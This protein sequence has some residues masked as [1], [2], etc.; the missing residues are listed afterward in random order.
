MSAQQVVFQY[1]SA[2]SNTLTVPPGFSN[3]VLV[4][5]W[6]AG[7]GA[8]YNGPAGG[9]GGFVQGIVTVS[10]GDTVVISVGGQGGVGPRDGSGI[11]GIGNTPTISFNGGTTGV[12]AP[13]DHNDDQNYG[14]GGGGGAATS[15]LVNGVPM[16]V[17]A[18]GGGGGGGRSYQTGSPGLAGG[19]ATL[20]STTPRGGTSPGGYSVGGAGGAG[21]PFGGAGGQTFGDDAG[22]ATGGYGGQN[23][24]NA[25]VT[26]STL[27]AGSGIT[28]GGVTNALYPKA[29][30]G[31]AGYDG[32]VI[33]I[34]TKNFRA[35]IKDTDWKE[36]NNAWVKVGDTP[37]TATRTVPV[38][39]GTV[40]DNVPGGKNITTSGA[41]NWPVPSGVTSLTVTA[42]GGGGGGGAV[43]TATIPVSTTR[44]VNHTTNLY[45]RY[46]AEELITWAEGLDLSAGLIDAT[47]RAN[48]KTQFASQVDIYFTTMTT[49]QR[50]TFKSIG[51]NLL[52]ETFDDYNTEFNELSSPVYI[53]NL[54]D[55]AIT[56]S[57]LEFISG[58][59]RYTRSTSRGSGT[60]TVNIDS[61]QRAELIAAYKSELGT[62]YSS[63]SGTLRSIYDALILYVVDE[64]QIPQ[65]N[66]ISSSVN[67][68][69]YIVTPTTGGVPVKV[70]GGGGGGS[71]GVTTSTL[72]VTPGEIIQID[73]GGGGA[74][75]GGTTTVRAASGT[76]TALGGSKGS[77]GTSSTGGSGGST[78]SGGSLGS[79]GPY[80]PSG[81]TVAGGAGGVNTGNYGNGGTGE[82]SSSSATA[83]NSG[84]VLI[85]YTQTTTSTTTTTREET[86]VVSTTAGGW[87]QITQA[88]IKD[89]DV[90]KPIQSG[91]SLVPVPS[92]SETVTINLTIAANANNYVLSD[93]LSGTSYIEGRSIV[94][95]TV[96]AGVIVGS[97]SA[98]ESAM[99][100]DGLAA[101]DLFNL[102]NNGNIAGAG[103]LGGAAGSY[104]SV[105]SGGGK[106]TNTFSAISPKGGYS[107][108]TTTVTSIPGRPGESGG[109]ALY[110][111]YQTN[112]VNNGTIAG[113]GGGGGG[114]GGPTGGQGGGGAGRIVGVGANNGTLT[115]GGAGT[116]LGGAGG[117]R[118]T[119]GSAGTNNTNAGG[120]GGAPGAAILGIDK[121]TITTA[122]TIIGERKVIAREV[123]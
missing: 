2:G 42:V 44:T 65:Y 57:G 74:I 78:A 89:N 21:Y 17:A 8:G 15:V 92:T 110:V 18:G 25:S 76:V 111:T 66:S 12:G 107:A 109:S 123:G 94:N 58:G 77:N 61:A 10:S 13:T 83:G 7:G 105:T 67:L 99:I 112:L 11:G 34:F 117:A 82:S 32:A 98:G 96:D 64:I 9:G 50:D 53:V 41:S 108:G 85:T 62:E 101:G 46:Y 37:T 70:S 73:V 31:Y 121:V 1:L 28:P 100:I 16:I 88:W 106:A 30:R 119:A 54:T 3:Q 63:S 90:W 69:D 95:L 93:F 5:A 102:I 87:K 29:K 97:T 24:A 4:Y 27:T 49:S 47:E 23:Y 59:N 36:I 84:A 118:G 75:S 38:P 81:G 43:G 6:G 79:S 45:Q 33:V 72:A 104:T 26:S 115:A 22:A 68:Y 39:I 114:G 52:D 20:T 71:G 56:G 103:G 19:V 14:A 120:L 91:V 116:G 51:N 40:I 80:S 122:G 48:Y 35:W 113:G 86:Y 55:A 60:F